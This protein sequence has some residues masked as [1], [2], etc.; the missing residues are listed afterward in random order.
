MAIDSTSRGA[1]K[2]SDLGVVEGDLSLRHDLDKL[3]ATVAQ[4]TVD[5]TKLQERIEALTI[6]NGKLRMQS[7]I[8]S[9]LERE[10]A[11]IRSKVTTGLV[12]GTKMPV[13][14]ATALGVGRPSTL[15]HR[16]PYVDCYELISAIYIDGLL[17]PRHLACRLRFRR[18][19]LVSLL[20]LLANDNAP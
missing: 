14:T 4:Q 19:T 16:T 8:I 7:D 20:V 13:P 5:V 17:D 15:D 18:N 11:E 10:L 2:S 3:K 6:E 12:N 9:R 1:S